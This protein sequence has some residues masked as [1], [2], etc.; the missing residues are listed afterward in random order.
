[1][2]VIGIKVTPQWHRDIFRDTFYGKFRD[3]YVYYIYMYFFAKIPPPPVLPQPLQRPAGL[4]Q[5]Q[6]TWIV[7]LGEVFAFLNDIF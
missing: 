7:S 4:V 2:A 1:M 5:A 3:M 6:V